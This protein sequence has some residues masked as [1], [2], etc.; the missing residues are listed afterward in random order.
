MNFLW[1]PASAVVRL[2]RCGAMGNQKAKS[3]ITRN[4]ENQK[5]KFKKVPGPPGVFAVKKS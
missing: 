4:K 1:H 3:Q 5:V 2:V